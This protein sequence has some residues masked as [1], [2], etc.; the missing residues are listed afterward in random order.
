MREFKPKKAKFG[1][2]EHFGNYNWLQVAAM[3][4]QV[5][6][7]IPPSPTTWFVE[8]NTSMGNC[9]V[10]LYINDEALYWHFKLVNPTK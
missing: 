5:T 10:K 3:I 2:E 8:M 6:E 7:G 1:F 9:S 4:N